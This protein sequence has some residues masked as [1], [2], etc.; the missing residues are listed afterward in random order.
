MDEPVVAVGSEELRP[1]EQVTAGMDRRQAFADDPSGW[2]ARA[3]NRTCGRT[4]ITTR[5]TTRTSAR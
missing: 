1:P 3:P 4:G 5:V 2:D